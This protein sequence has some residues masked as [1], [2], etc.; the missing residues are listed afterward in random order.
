MSTL[1]EFNN[2]QRNKQ[3]CCYHN[4]SNQVEIA[5]VSNIDNWYLE[6]IVFP[7]E[8]FLFEAPSYAELEIYNSGKGQPFLKQKLSCLHLIVDEGGDLKFAS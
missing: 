1:H 6:H 8:R 4:D 3:L 2:H 7:G 5:R